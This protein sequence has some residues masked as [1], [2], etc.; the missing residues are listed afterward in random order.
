MKVSQKVVLISSA[1]VAIT[2]TLFSWMQYN[3]VKNA[4]YDNAASNVSETSAVISSQIS[5]WLNGKLDLI[6]I[7]AQNID[8]NYSPSAIQEAIDVPILEDKF[9]LIFGGLDTDG[10][11]ITNDPSWRPEG[12]DARKRP[13]YNVARDNSRATLT[14]PYEDAATKEVLISAVANITDKGKFLGA[15]GGDL[16]LK[17]IAETINKVNFNNTGYAFLISADGNII[18]HPDNQLNGKNISELYNGKQPGIKTELQEANIN[19]QIVLTSFQPLSELKGSN[20]YIG[21]ALNK[22]MVLQEATRFGYAAIVGALVSVLLCALA[23]FFTMKSLFK[24]LEGLQSSIIEINSGEGDLTKRLTVVSNDEFGTVSSDFNNFLQQLQGII[25]DIKNISVD[26]NQNTSKSSS[27]AAKTAS[28]LIKQ[29]DELDSLSAAINEMSYSA[30]EVAD[31][32]KKAADAAQS[33]DSAASEGTAI[34][35]KTSQSIAQLVVDMEDTVRTVNQLE[36]YSDDIESVLTSITS[37]AQQTNLLALNAAIE[38]ARAGDMGRGFAVVADEV[39]ALAARTQQSTN[40]TSQ[41]IEHLQAGV[42][43]AVE[44]IESSRSLADRT[45]EEA[46]KA[47]EILLNI[48]SSISEINDISVNIASAAQQQSNTSEEINRNAANIRDISQTVS[49]Q[50]QDQSDLCSVIVDHTEQQTT[51]LHKFK[52]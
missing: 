32:A 51:V 30:K 43:E 18:S 23:L 12:W 2:F 44:K 17:L 41:I 21:V 45:N 40:E 24:P 39:R 46:S 50:A 52:V 7:V 20:W 15:F 8:E 25:L 47:D 36:K 26:I 11:P 4:L 37:I 19:D 38:A 14:A 22:A 29:L 13:W 33:A 5:H 27:S 28:D 9:I 42:K 35:T 49:T 48:R 6:D 3:T 10:K 1:I 16:S 31:N 34:V